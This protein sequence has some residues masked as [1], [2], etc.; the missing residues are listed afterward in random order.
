MLKIVKNSIL[1]FVDSL[2]QNPNRCSQL[3]NSKSLNIR[4]H[5]I[6]NLRIIFEKDNNTVYITNIFY[7]Q[8]RI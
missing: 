3:K 1:S 4:F 2:S 6:K 7:A 5:I 8:K